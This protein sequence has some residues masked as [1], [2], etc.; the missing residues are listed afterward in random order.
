MT[1]FVTPR[2]IPYFSPQPL[3]LVFNY[4][5]F[6]QQAAKYLFSSSKAD[7]SLS[8]RRFHYICSSCR[9]KF[10]PLLISIVLFTE[11]SIHSPFFKRL[12]LTI[13]FFQILYCT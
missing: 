10:P 4:I 7:H 9:V 6:V 13:L 1:T 12:S 8:I 3:P 11:L 5:V 2:N